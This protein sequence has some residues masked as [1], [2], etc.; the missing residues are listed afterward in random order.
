M[1]HLPLTIAVHLSKN[2]R[3]A[4]AQHWFHYIFDPTATDPSVPP[5]ARFWKFLA[6]RQDSEAGPLADQLALLS[7]P[8]A[9][10]SAADRQRR[11]AILA[12]YQASLA[13]PFQPHAVARTR[14]LAYQYCVVMKYLDNLIAWG[15]YLFQ[16]DTVEAINEATQRYVL[17]A[18]LLGPRPQRVPAQGSTAPKTF[19]QLK[20]AAGGL[21]A[22]GNAL[23]D[24]ESRFPFNQAAAPG[25]GGA[26]ASSPLVGLGRTLYFCIPQNEKLL[27]YWDTVADR[28]FKIRHCM[29]LAGVV[30][31]LALFD[32]PLDPGMLVHAAAAG[33][34]VD[35]LVAGATPAV[36]PVRALPLIGK[37][38]EL[39]GEVRGLGAALLAALE[40]GDSAHLAAVRQ[41]H[42]VQLQ[43]LAQELRLLQWKQAQEATT[44]LLASRG[45][46]LER[47]HYYQRLLGLP[48]DPNAP[49]ALPLDRRDLNEA[50][51]DDAYAALVDQYAQ[52]AAL[53]PWPP[54]R[55]AGNS[56][57]AQ[58]A[59]ASG[60]GRLYLNPNED[61][62]LNTH[63]PNAKRDLAMAFALRQAAPLLALLPEHTDFHPWGVGGTLIL[64]GPAA[65]ENLKTAA[66]VF[67]L[68]ASWENADAA[69]AA[70]T[71]GYR[72]RADEWLLQYNLAA[73]ELMQ[74]GRQILGALIAE[75]VALHD[76]RSM[77]Q[78]VAQAQEVA[79]LLQDQFTNEELYGWMQGEIARLYYEYYRLA[80]DTA[81]KAETTLKQEL[82]RPELDAQTFVRFNYWDGGR[83]GLLAGDALY[84]DVKRMELAY[85]DNNKREL[86]LSRSVSL[87]QLDPLALLTLRATGACRVTI[88]E[89]LYDRDC[90][91]HYM[92]RIKS[93][94]VSLPAVVG[95]YTAVN[96]TLTLLSSTLRASPQTADGYARQSPQDARFVDYPGGA[97][98]IV[99]SG[100]TADSGMFE[101]NLRDERFLPFEGAGAISTWQLEL[102]PDYRAFDYAT[103]ADVIL[104]VHYTAR[105]GVDRGAVHAALQT[106]FQDAD[107]ATLAVLFSLRHDFPTEWAA[108]VSGS[109]PF[110]ATIRREYFPY[111]TQGRPLADVRLAMYGPDLA[112]SAQAVQTTGDS[113]R[114]GRPRPADVHGDRR[115][116]PAAR[117]R[118]RCLRDPALHRGVAPRGAPRRPEGRKTARARGR[119]ISGGAPGAAP[120]A[121]GRRPGTRGSTRRRGARRTGAPS[122]SSSAGAG[123]SHA[124]SLAVS[125]R[126]APGSAMSPAG[127]RPCGACA[128]RRAHSTAHSGPQ[129]R[130]PTAR[131]WSPCARRP[132]SLG[133]RGR[134]PPHLL[135]PCA[136]GPSRAPGPGRRTAHVSRRGGTS[137][138]S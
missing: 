76:Y 100:A 24:L 25:A 110:T 105:P 115:P 30:R 67:E 10:L 61:M 35:A 45:P 62:E 29:N 80:C 26:A 46:V 68:L 108:F 134:R 135:Q 86:E 90:P 36:G 77:Q 9:E 118:G 106:L 28:L 75:Q 37:A 70:T 93:V 91:G 116:R 31:P 89:W 132:S 12:G 130:W 123:V 111:F 32:P 22:M 102:P 7:T 5:P 38:L 49:D 15:D 54:L 129:R 43:Q 71:A 51:F 44:A 56:A 120:G 33:L 79:Q 138:L 127:A 19:A 57:P 107:Q 101:T 82:M 40:R 95:P 74:I 136:R 42:E 97:E 2:Q 66:D 122:A 17:A 16:Q 52:A 126:S 20:N 81:R 48:A 47:L 8:E 99:T 109:G 53:Q 64:G 133:G 121:A 125:A 3:F 59:G 39:A 69:R 88:P 21:D 18:N 73:R 84:L 34:D 78:Q 41:G 128:G 98:S 85:Y 92:R 11:A 72:R 6:F 27:A 83:K 112:P 23:V 4:E 87:R 55:I 114:S 96:G 58:Q 63:L 113:R 14:H 119:A 13:A 1:F 103:I 124:T 131:A 117:G 60:P 104:H 137:V 50:T 65:T 94:A